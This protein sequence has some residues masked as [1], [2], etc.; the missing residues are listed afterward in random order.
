MHITLGVFKIRLGKAAYSMKFERLFLSLLFMGTLGLGWMTGCTKQ[1]T[2][3]VPAGLPTLQPTATP[4]ETFTAPYQTPTVSVP[5][6]GIYLVADTQ[7]NFFTYVNL[8]VN[9]APETTATVTLTTP[10]G[11]LSLPYFSGNPPSALAPYFTNAGANLPGS[12]YQAGGV[13][14]LT[15]ATSIGTVSASVTAPGGSVNFASDGSQVSWAVEGDEDYATVTRVSPY[16]TTYQS[17]ATVEDVTSPLSIPSSAYPTTGT[18]YYLTLFAQ[19]T[20]YNIPGTQAGSRWTITQVT[21][22]TLSK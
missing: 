7:N 11:P 1:L 9:G 12:D 17:F 14:T 8:A 16:G 6:A 18:S 19:S 5:P 10:S 21:T 20:L 4:T 3:V 13:Y 2:P 15:V 22:D